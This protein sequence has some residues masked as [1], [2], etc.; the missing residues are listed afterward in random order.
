MTNHFMF[1]S[2]NIKH[3]LLQDFPNR[4]ADLNV[5]IMSSG[6]FQSAAL[7]KLIQVEKPVLLWAFCFY[8]LINRAHFY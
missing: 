4:S 1:I 3:Y 6:T 5:S 8:V 2:A 7:K